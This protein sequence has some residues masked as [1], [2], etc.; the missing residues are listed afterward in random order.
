MKDIKDNIEKLLTNFVKKLLTINKL[1]FLFCK[2]TII[3]K[4][5]EYFDKFQ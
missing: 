3:M 5:W 2:I 1:K 4:W